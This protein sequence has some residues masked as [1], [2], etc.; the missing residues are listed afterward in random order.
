M[1]L[2][3]GNLVKRALEDQP[4]RSRP[5]SA[6][7]DLESFGED[8]ISEFD[9]SGAGAVEQRVLDAGGTRTAADVEQI[10]NRAGALSDRSF[11]SARGT[12]SRQQ[13]ALGGR[14]SA[15]D[16][17]SQERRLG[18]AQVL[19][20]VDS[21]NRAIAS[22]QERRE[23]IRRDAGSL[24]D[25]IDQSALRGLSSAA[26]AEANREVQFRRDKAQYEQ[27]RSAGLGALA[28]LGLSF[29][30]GGQFAAPLVQG[31]L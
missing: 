5:V 26:G 4:G 19:S 13:R 12:L 8:Y 21:R 31:A 24:R 29:I 1:T 3:I 18:L 30:P 9:R 14:V 2:S 16:R 10:G 23:V 22:D 27:E 15:R 20:N 6:I 28:G 11:A 25:L 17:A 7:S